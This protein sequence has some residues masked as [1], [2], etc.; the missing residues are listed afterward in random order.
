VLAEAIIGMLETRAI[1]ERDL[2]TPLAAEIDHAREDW[3]ERA[4]ELVSPDGSGRA[5]GHA[6]ASLAPPISRCAGLE[7]RVVMIAASDPALL[8]H[9]S[10]TAEGSGATAITA[11]S[12]HVALAVARTFVIDALVCVIEGPSDM[13]LALPRALAARALAPAAR[14]ALYRVG[15]GLVPDDAELHGFG[16][17]VPLEAA[18]HHAFTTVIGSAIGGAEDAAPS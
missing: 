7:H 8:V 3:S 18:L 13:L 1:A 11:T 6:Q 16:V 5:R 2:G 9:L 15:C 10:A 14:I 4:R 17:V 12:T